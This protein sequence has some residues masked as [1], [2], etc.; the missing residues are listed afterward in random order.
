VQIRR[1]VTSSI[2][3]EVQVSILSVKYVR[4]A[5][6]LLA[7]ERCRSLLQRRMQGRLFTALGSVRVLQRRTRV[8]ALPTTNLITAEYERISGLCANSPYGM[9][10][11]PPVSSHAIYQ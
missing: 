6:P 9:D 10:G 2:K 1:L 5:I 3:L 4:G 11:S 8:F 7:T